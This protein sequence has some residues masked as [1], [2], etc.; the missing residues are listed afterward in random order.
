MDVEISR[1]CGTLVRLLRHKLSAMCIGE[2]L[3]GT[4]CYVE[5][6]AMPSFDLEV[7]DI[8]TSHASV[9][10]LVGILRLFAKIAK[11]KNMCITK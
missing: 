5:R 11:I 4:S 6:K 1:M 10:H 9:W 3:L 7:T 8:D 2:T